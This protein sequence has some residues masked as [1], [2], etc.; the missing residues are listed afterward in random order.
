MCR[1]GNVFVGIGAEYGYRILHFGLVL[2]V[3][4]FMTRVSHDD[5][6]SHICYELLLLMLPLRLNQ[7]SSK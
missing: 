4:G 2:T 6:T 3:P 1:Y 5:N 7:L